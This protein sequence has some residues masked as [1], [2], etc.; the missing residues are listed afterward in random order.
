MVTGS[1]TA[2]VITFSVDSNGLVRSAEVSAFS[3]VRN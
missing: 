1:A 2:M 3:L